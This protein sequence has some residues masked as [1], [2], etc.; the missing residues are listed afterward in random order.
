VDYPFLAE[1]LDT[2]VENYRSELESVDF[3]DPEQREAAR[4]AINAWVEEATE[5]KI[6]ELLK[7]GVL[8]RNTRLALINAIY[9]NAKWEVPFLDGTS[10]RNFNLLDGS[11]LSVP[12]M[13]R[14]AYTR[15]ANNAEYEVLDIPYRGRPMSMVIFVP[16]EGTFADVEQ[17]LNGA[18]V[19]QALE[20]LTTRDVKLYLPKFQYEKDFTLN[21]T[22]K[23]MGITDI[24]DPDLADLSGMDGTLLLYLAHLIHKAFIEVNELGTEA[25]AATAGLVSIEEGVSS[26]PIIVRVNRPF[27][28]MIRDNETGTVLFA[29]RVLDPSEE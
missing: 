24:F 29:G 2:I 20:T 16:K 10:D 19:T 9:F 18:S 11:Q 5:D 25:A 23:D 14:H 13:S 12:T 7:P 28:Y 22:L 3:V 15:Y 4:L 21:Q 17:S 1:Y 6:K 27:I 26:P 8:T